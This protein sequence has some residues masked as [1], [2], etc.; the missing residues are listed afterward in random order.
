LAVLAN[1][2]YLPD[3]RWLY[4]PNGM[5]RVGVIQVKEDSSGDLSAE[6]RVH[7][8]RFRFDASFEQVDKFTAAHSP[9]IEVR[10]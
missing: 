9:Y 7:P 5:G 2:N 6:F 10:P 3:Q 8:E 4:A 1:K